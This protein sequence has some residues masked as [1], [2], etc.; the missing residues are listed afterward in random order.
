MTKAVDQIKRA[1]S[2]VEK[3]KTR[4]SEIKGRLDGLLG[5]LKQE[6]GCENVAEAVD[7][8]E[9]LDEE[10]ADMKQQVAA[11]EEELDDMVAE[12]EEALV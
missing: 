1:E 6:F 10:V 2:A 7:R 4:R 5:E 3:I 11:A 12:I 8:L 9:K